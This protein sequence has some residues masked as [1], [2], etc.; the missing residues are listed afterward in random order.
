MMRKLTIFLF[1]LLTVGLSFS[2]FLKVGFLLGSPYAFWKVQTF[3][4]IDYD[5]LKRV[6]QL[7]DYQLEVYVLPFS[8]LDPTVLDK[9]GLDIIA[10]GIHMTEERQK[11]YTFSIPY[12]ESGL[13]IVLR[14]G[15]QWNG[16]VEK[17][18]FG[19]KHGATGE[20]IVKEWVNTG[21]KVKSVSFVS[22]EEIIANMITRKIDAAFFDYINALYIA[23]TYD[24]TVFKELIYKINVGYII[25]DKNIEKKFN[26]ILK[27]LK[28]TYINQ[29]LI[30]YIGTIK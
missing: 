22:N 25:L 26:E 3:G 9:I 21:K 28:S 24:F 19:V 30:S 23:R 16:D 5:I 8:A 29:V 10:G 13:A 2:Q 1:I 7:M 20:K 17:I 18:T 14:K 12:V 6:A 4:G 27:S 11:L 15:I